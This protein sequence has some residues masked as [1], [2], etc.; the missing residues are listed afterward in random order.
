MK[1]DFIICGYYTKNTPYEEEIKHLVATCKQFDLNVH[2]QG[3]DSRGSWV[4]NC[5]IKGEFVL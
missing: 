5:A 4:Q 3:Y 1:R 2:T